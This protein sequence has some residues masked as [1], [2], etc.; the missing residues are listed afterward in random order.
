MILLTKFSINSSRL[1]LLE[2]KTPIPLPCHI[3]CLDLV[4]ITSIYKAPSDVV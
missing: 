2:D 3:N 1:A 4:S